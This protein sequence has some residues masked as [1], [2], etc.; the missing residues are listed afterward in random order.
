LSNRQDRVD[1]AGHDG[2]G[3]ARQVTWMTCLTLA[4]LQQFCPLTLGLVSQYIEG[5]FFLQRENGQ[6]SGIS[7]ILGYKPWFRVKNNHS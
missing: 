7:C 3:K 2:Q 5:F 1:P 6:E 4:D